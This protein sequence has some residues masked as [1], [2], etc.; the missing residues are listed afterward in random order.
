MAQSISFSKL[1]FQSIQK[2]PFR[3]IATILCFIVISGSLLTSYFLV[4]GA[5]KSLEVGMGF[6]GADVLVTPKLSGGAAAMA[7][8]SG[9]PDTFQFK[10][11]GSDAVLATAKPSDSRFR[12]TVLEQISATEG[13]DR[14]APQIF[15]GTLAN[16][17]CC[18][19]RF[20]VIAIDPE[21]DFTIGPWMETKLGR[22]LRPGEV[23]VGNV[24]PGEIG[25]DLMFYGKNFTIVARLDPTGM[26]MDGSAFILMEDAYTMAAESKTRAVTPLNIRPGD[27]SA[28]LVRVKPGWDKDVVADRINETIPDTYSFKDNYLSKKITSQ[29]YATTQLLYAIIAA[30][31]LVSI[32]F[33]A[34]ISS[35]V[36]NERRREFAILRA[37]GA[38]KGFIF[39]LVFVEALLIAAIGGLAGVVISTIILFFTEPLI[40]GSLEIPFIWP[41]LGTMAVNATI[42][43]LVAIGIGA[44]AAVIPAINSSKEEPY[45]AI[46]SGER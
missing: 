20:Q 7:M 42:T 9:N 17:P 25:S 5:E 27:I 2:R 4:S 3:T 24:M 13:V 37:L 22:T 39:R 29:L 45:E 12:G 19:G 34:L 23:V 26:G 1:V 8:L 35:M 11:P 18:S 6:L 14:A 44:S 16:Q 21:R 31:T 10:R 36:A 32:P 15:I 46:R 28:V 30:V 38:T 40:I 41:S 43:V 33:I